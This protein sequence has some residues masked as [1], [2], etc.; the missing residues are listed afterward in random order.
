[1][2]SLAGT[3]CFFTKSPQKIDF[4]CRNTMFVS[5]YGHRKSILPA[6]NEPEKTLDSLRNLGNEPEKP[7]MAS[8]MKAAHL[9]KTIHG[10][11]NV[12]NEP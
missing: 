8:Q 10:L 6:G 12:G 9:K 3:Q 11:I 2:I 1:M 5:L 4:A 7:S